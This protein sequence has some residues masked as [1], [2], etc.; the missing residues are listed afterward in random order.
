MVRISDAR[1]SGSAFGTIILHVTPESNICGPLSVVKTGD[2]IKLSA[3]NKT[4]DLLVSEEEI[5]ERLLKFKKNQVAYKRGYKYLYQKH[6]LPATD[7]CDFDFLTKC[8]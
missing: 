4:I 7:G 6:V 1:M 2:K 3:E 8:D 5:K